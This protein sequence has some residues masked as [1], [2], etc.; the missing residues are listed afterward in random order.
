[1]YTNKYCVLEGYVDDIDLNASVLHASVSLVGP[2]DG[3][4]G[5]LASSDFSAYLYK[6]ALIWNYVFIT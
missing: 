4:T 2:Q 3:P 5:R 1:M 6:N